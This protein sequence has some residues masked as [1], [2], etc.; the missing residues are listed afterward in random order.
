MPIQFDSSKTE[1]NGKKNFIH[2]I[3]KLVKTSSYT[4]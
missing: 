1:E 4:M 2:N 3:Y